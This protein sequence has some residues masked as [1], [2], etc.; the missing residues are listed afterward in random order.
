MRHP[1]IASSGLAKAAAAI[2]ACALPALAAAQMPANQ[3]DGRSRCESLA[4]L[5]LADTTIVS[6]STIAKE[7][8]R[9]R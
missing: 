4:T 2:L 6:T 7:R 1:V 8:P 3:P 5:P 9:L